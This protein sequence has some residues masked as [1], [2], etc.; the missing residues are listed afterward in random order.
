MNNKREN[1]YASENVIVGSLLIFSDRLRFI[2]KCLDFDQSKG[3]LNF[4]VI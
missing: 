2:E 3:N 4:I 1:N